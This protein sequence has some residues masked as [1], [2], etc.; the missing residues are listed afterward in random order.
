M[1]RLRQ[2]MRHASGTVP[3][4]V[5]NW[6][7]S[8]STPST[9]TSTSMPLPQPWRRCCRRPARS[10]CAGSAPCST[11]RTRGRPWLRPGDDRRS[12]NRA[13]A[14]QP[15]QRRVPASRGG[16][17]GVRRERAA[18]P[19]PLADRPDRRDQGIRHRLTAVGHAAR[20]ARRRQARWRAGSISRTSRRRSPA[21]PG[22]GHGSTGAAPASRCGR[23]V[24]CRSIVPSSTARRRRCSPI[25]GSGSSSR[26]S[27]DVPGS[28]AIGGDCYAYAQLAMGHVDVVVDTDLQALRHRRSDGDRRGCRRR[29]V[30]PRRRVGG[31]MA[32]SSWRPVHP[33][34]PTR[35]P[36]YRRDAAIVTPQRAD[37]SAR[38][39]LTAPAVMPPTMKRWRN[40]NSS[41]TGIEAISAPTANGPQLR[42]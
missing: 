26:P 37:R 30:R 24:A 21:S 9:P 28:C 35:S 25:R 17:R 4:R 12:G 38:Q 13:A 5:T 3:A 15:A 18:R 6:Y 41:T 19:L 27:A 29:R 1:V 2:P 20:P 23:G 42:S 8:P 16:R 14:A 31:A 10:P 36:P 33:S 34:W 11:P 22:A 39:P 32:A 40:W 7:R